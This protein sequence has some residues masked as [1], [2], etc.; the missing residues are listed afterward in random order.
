MNEELKVGDST[1]CFI[2]ATLRIPIKSHYAGDYRLE[3]DGK[4]ITLFGRDKNYPG[5]DLS[6]NNEIWYEE[7]VLIGCALEVR[8]AVPTIKEV[9]ESEIIIDLGCIPL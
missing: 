3:Y 1:E 7:M 9:T 8:N 6:G 5:W 4:Y 2:G